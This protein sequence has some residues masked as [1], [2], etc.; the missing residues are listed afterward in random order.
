MTA[1]TFDHT[2]GVPRCDQPTQDHICSL[3]AS[4]LTTAIL[5]VVT[6]EHHAEG[7]WRDLE[8]TLTRQDRMPRSPRSGTSSGSPIGFSV[9][10]SEAKSQLEATVWYWVYAVRRREPAPGL[11]PLLR[12]GRRGVH[13]DCPVPRPDRSAAER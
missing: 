1:I 7:L 8:V 11:R 2:C 5:R 9:R 12:H 4:E 6:A 13:L 3:C 10:A